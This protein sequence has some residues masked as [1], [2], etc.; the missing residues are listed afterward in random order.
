M[1]PVKL[2]IKQ[3]P[4]YKGYQIQTQKNRLLKKPVFDIEDILERYDI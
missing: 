2:A 3:T 1:F 4:N